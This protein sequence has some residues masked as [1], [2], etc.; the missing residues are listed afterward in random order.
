MA[1]RRFSLILLLGAFCACGA[2]RSKPGGTATSDCPGGGTTRC[3]GNAHQACHDGAWVTDVTCP[4]ACDPDAGCVP[5]I[6]GANYCDGSTIRKC[7]SDGKPGDAVT[8]CSGACA[9]GQCV[10]PCSQAAAEFSYIGCDY[11]PTVT[12]NSELTD[13]AH[14]AVAIANPNG[15]PAEVKITRPGLMPDVQ[16]MVPAGD[17]ITI[18]LP[19]VPELKQISAG[20]SLVKGGAYKLSAS[21]PVTV[22]QFNPLEFE[23]NP[24]GMMMSCPTYTNDASLLL[25]QNTLTGHYI[26]IA[27]PSFMFQDKSG[28]PFPS[29]DYRAKY[30]GFIAVVGTENTTTNVTLTFSA[31]TMAGTGGAIAAYKKGQQGTFKLQQQDVLQIFS[32]VPDSCTPNFTEKQDPTDPFGL[33]GTYGY[34]DLPNYDLTGTEVYADQKIAVFSGHNCT[35]VP[36]NRWACD[37]LEEQIFPLESW[38]KKYVVAKTQRMPPTIP[39]LIRVV[40]GSDANTITFS[41][42]ST[43]APVTLDRD[44]W[45]EFPAP[46]DFVAEGTGAF[47]VAQFMVGEDYAGMSSGGNNPGDPAMALA[48]PIEQYRTNYIFLTPASY[49]MNFVNVTAPMGTDVTLDGQVIAAGQW[50]PI[51]GGEFVAARLSVPAGTHSIKASAPFGIEVYGLAPYTSY[52]YPG[53]LDVKEINIP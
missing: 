2:S 9:G 26:A 14:F 36:Y 47:A 42:A 13:E 48:V 6:A 5:C 10:D 33:S 35:F 29:T 1:V 52:M 38:G 53:G 7:T 17:L 21:L 49:V 37:H 23:V 12:A 44:Q 8:Q 40:S 50:K 43:H 41:P 22:Y 25:P 51:A 16:R 32:A 18:Q 39:D 45:M 24:C 31:P 11:W 15:Q 4:A 3:E 19:W 20:S 27:R 34:C 30:P 28:G 46:A